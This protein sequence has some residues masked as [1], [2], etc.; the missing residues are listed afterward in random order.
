MH[1]VLTRDGPRLELAD[2]IMPCI[3]DLPDFLRC[4]TDS[5]LNRA[6]R[7]WLPTTGSVHNNIAA[8]NISCMQLLVY[9]HLSS[10][11]ME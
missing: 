5:E 10:S 11:A 4:D 1:G 7:D 6:V 2:D 9:T 8:R 3:E